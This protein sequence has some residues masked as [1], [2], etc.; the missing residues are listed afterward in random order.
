MTITR[1][2]M[3]ETRAKLLREMDDWLYENIYD[4][5]VIDY[6]LMYGVPDGADDEMLLD[7]AS[8]DSIWLNIIKAFDEVLKRESE[9]RV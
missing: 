7:F 1:K 9:V 8:D 2:E 6:W 3:V 4:E 5:D